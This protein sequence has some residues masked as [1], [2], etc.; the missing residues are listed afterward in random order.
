MDMLAL[1]LYALV[2]TGQLFAAAFLAYGA[3]L[4]VRH[5]T[6]WSHFTWRAA[7]PARPP[8]PDLAKGSGVW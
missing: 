3:Y 2:I 5:A 6:G 8:L 4:C 1:L 7:K